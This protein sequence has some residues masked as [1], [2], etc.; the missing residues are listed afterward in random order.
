MVGDIAANYGGKAYCIID[1][2]FQGT[3][4]AQSILDSMHAHGIETVENYGVSANPR[5]SVMDEKAAEC[6]E[7]GCTLVVAMGGGSCLDI[8]KAV[9]MLVTNG[10]G[11]W[12]YAT[13]ENHKFYDVEVPPLPLIVL[14]TTSGTGSEGTIYSVVTAPEL[15]RK[16]TIRSFYMYPAYAVIDP[17][18]MVGIPPMLTALTGIDTFAHAYESYMNKSATAFSRMVAM[19]SMR[20][21]VEN[22]DECVHNGKNAEARAAMAQASLFGGIAIAHS[23]TTLPHIIGQCLSGWV[24]APH[25][26]SLACCLAQVIR[27]TVP[28]GKED[29]A[30][31]ARLFNKDLLL[32]DDETAAL[33][34]P[35]EIDKLFARILPEKITM[36]TYGMDPD[37]IEEFADFIYDNYQGDLKNNLKSPSREDIR[38]IIKECM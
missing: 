26:G 16:C 35:D 13:V 2:V 21:F 29:H 23:P 36:S 15:Q 22:I 18:L 7:N 9:A 12:D 28:E 4:A 20:L 24:D 32:V 27:W 30:R 1:P 11:A 14:P 37:R 8:G 6:K 3:D 19:E 17:E 25:G 34:L 33:A 38:T 5:A 31:I 10:R